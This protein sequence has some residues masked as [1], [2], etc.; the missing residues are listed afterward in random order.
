MESFIDD[1]ALRKF[2][3]KVPSNFA[4]YRSPILSLIGLELKLLSRVFTPY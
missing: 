3:S 1:V 2:P 4:G